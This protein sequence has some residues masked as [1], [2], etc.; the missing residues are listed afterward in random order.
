MRRPGVRIPS[1]PPSFKTTSSVPNSSYRGPLGLSSLPDSFRYLVIH[2]ERHCLSVTSLVNTSR[3]ERYRSP[4]CNLDYFRVATRELDAR[5]VRSAF[6]AICRDTS[7][8]Y[9]DYRQY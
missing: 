7:M 6:P 9:L 1:R 5:F 2:P 3:L 8:A 4:C